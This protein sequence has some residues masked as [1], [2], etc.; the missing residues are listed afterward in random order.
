VTR[1]KE[2]SKLEGFRVEGVEAAALR[3]G[4]LRCNTCP[5]PLMP[6]NY[7]HT[8]HPNQ[9]RLKTAVRILYLSIALYG[10]GL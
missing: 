2:I 10:I 6:R 8:R 3:S 1:I 4:V 5:S 7:Q 9:P